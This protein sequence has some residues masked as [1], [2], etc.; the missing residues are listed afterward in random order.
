MNDRGVFLL[1]PAYNEAAHLPSVLAELATLGEGFTVVVVDDGSRD[2][3]SE[4][5]R[6]GGALVVRHPFNM[7][8]GAALQTGY[9]FALERGASFLVQMDSDGQHDPGEIEKILA[10][11]AAGEL[12][13]AIGSRFFPGSEYESGLAK[14][15]GRRIICSLARLLGLQLEDPTSGFQAMNRDVIRLYCRDTF[16]YDYP[17]L[18]V[19]VLARRG[20]LRIG[21]RP[22]AMRAGLRPSQLHGGLKP[23]YYFYRLA[24]ALLAT[25][26]AKRESLR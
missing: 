4:V 6:A 2:A 19:L 10:P 18:D 7:G 21:E 16:P 5:A 17:D 20:G 22:T 25:S 11:V 13:L 9:K 14:G 24:L 8:Y 12:D 3:T 26:T 1:L 15:V 23:V